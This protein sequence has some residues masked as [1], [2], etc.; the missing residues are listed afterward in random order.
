MKKLFCSLLIGTAATSLFMLTGCGLD[1]HPAYSPGIEFGV[2]L[3]PII[4]VGTAADLGDDR[5][6]PDRPGV[7]PLVKYD[8]IF[9]P[10]HPMY[11]KSA[12][13]A[14]REMLRDPANL[15]EKDRKELVDALKAHFGTPANPTI[16]AKLT[17]IDEATVKQLQLDDATLAEGSTRYRV[18]CMHCHG[19][20]GDGRGPTA[21]WI[22]PHP[23]DFRQGVFK[24]QSVDQATDGQ[25]RPPSRGDLERTLRQGLEGTAMPTFGILP[26]RDIDTLISYVMVLSI[27]GKTEY[28]IIKGC[29]DFDNKAKMLVWNGV[30]PDTKAAA[31]FFSNQTI[32]DGW[33]V[34]NDP[35]RKIKV[36]P[37]PYKDGDVDALK[38]SVMLGQQL[39]TGSKEHP[40][41]D[42][43]NCK[44]CHDDYGRQA[45]F[46]FDEWGTFVRPNNFTQGTFR[47]GRRPVDMYYRI[48]SGI[49]GSGMARFGK[50]GV[51]EGQDIWDLIN[52]ITVLSYPPMR[53]KLGIRID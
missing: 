49:N 13:I 6:E 2:R 28:E 34:A 14:E 23:R 43:A 48:H 10:E 21:R 46:K 30:F 27:R 41:G 32:M 26:D 25:N 52:F 11:A 5:F 1:Q 40:R 3:D 24:F 7:L 53:D 15:T 8:D 17:G 33:K 31:Q 18:H 38:K 37:Y 35:A 39:F 20:P 19:V 12:K 4:M 36:Y 42:K 50:A 44:Q 51:L 16:N 47:G 29:Y 45:R 9:K 22:N